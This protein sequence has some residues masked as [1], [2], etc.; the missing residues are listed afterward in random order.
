M[1]AAC[2]KVL[3]YS[4][5]SAWPRDLLAQHWPAAVVAALGQCTEFVLTHHTGYYEQIRHTFDEQDAAP[6]HIT[7][8]LLLGDLIHLWH[9]E[10]CPAPQDALRWI[11]VLAG[12]PDITTVRT[13]EAALTRAR[14]FRPNLPEPPA[15]EWSRIL[16][17]TLAPLAYATGF[18][19]E[20]AT[21]L[22][23]A[24]RLDEPGLRILAGL[25]GFHLAFDTSTISD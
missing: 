12:A 10:H 5:G 9:P 20:E 18:T 22:H 14:T 3:G 16:P 25:R 17:A 23:A 13:I 1:Q 2:W 24:G 21:T 15:Y 19:L 11:E 8:R 6:T 4:V 7:G